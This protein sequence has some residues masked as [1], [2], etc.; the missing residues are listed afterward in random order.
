MHCIGRTF[1][2]LSAEN[3]L[4]LDRFRRRH[5]LTRER[6]VNDILRDFFNGLHSRA[7]QPRIRRRRVS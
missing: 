7:H 4:H 1:V 6:V 3:R 5:S 2:R